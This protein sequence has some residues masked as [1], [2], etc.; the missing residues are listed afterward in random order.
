MTEPNPAV[1][2]AE[3][4]IM[5]LPTLDSGCRKRHVGKV[6]SKLQPTFDLLK[7]VH[8]LAREAQVSGI[9]KRFGLLDEIERLTREYDNET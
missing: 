9:G 4:I 6:E 3:E 8:S 2:L 1:Q 5:V 7:R